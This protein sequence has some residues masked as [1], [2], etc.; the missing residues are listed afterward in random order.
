MLIRRIEGADK[1]FGDPGDVKTGCAGLPVMTV[2]TESG[3]FFVSAWEPT[4]EELKR[5][6]EGKSVHLWVRGPGHP[7]VAL[8][9]EE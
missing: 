1:I 3:V 2:E 9:V 6:L 8:G 4:P 5:L 7:V